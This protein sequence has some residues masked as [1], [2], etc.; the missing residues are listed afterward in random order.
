MIK[1]AASEGTNI[2][3]PLG[4]SKEDWFI[5]DEALNKV[6]KSLRKIEKE[7][8]REE[9]EAVEDKSPEIL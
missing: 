3:K 1:Q 7:Q 4:L 8:R 9:L 2:T 6:A 5:I